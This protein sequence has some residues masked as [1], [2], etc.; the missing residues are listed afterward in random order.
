MRIDSVSS[1]LNSNAQ[2]YA[3]WLLSRQWWLTHHKGLCSRR[4]SA[5][6][7]TAIIHLCLELVVDG[8]D[9]T[10]GGGDEFDRLFFLTVLDL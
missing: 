5:R 3:K 10:S 4:R 8:D 6:V 1:A 2:F 7:D 9:F